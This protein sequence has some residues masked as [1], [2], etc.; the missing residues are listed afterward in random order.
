M[1]RLLGPTL[2]RLESELLNPIIE[3]C[4]NMMLRSGAFPRPP[5]NIVEFSR[6]KHGLIDIEYEGPLARAQRSQELVAIQKFNDTMAPM[7][8]LHPEVMDVVDDD[9][10]ARKVARVSGFPSDCLRSEVAVA[11]IRQK[12]LAAQEKQNQ[13]E[14]MSTMADAAGKAA[15]VLQMVGGQAGAIA[16]APAPGGA[17]TK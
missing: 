5:Q 15:P 2:G 6:K 3:R 16:G 12:R 7:A 4:F 8:S 1:Q 13:L 9:M 10:V 14:E 17:P 11:D